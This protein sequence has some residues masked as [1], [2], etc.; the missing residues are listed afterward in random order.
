MTTQS[1]STTGGGPP[2]NSQECHR[3][4]ETVRTRKHMLC[5]EGAAPAQ[6]QRDLSCGGIAQLS[7]VFRSFHDVRYF[8]SGMWAKPESHPVCED[9]GATTSWIL[10]KDSWPPMTWVLKQ[11]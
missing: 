8:Y 11:K 9:P 5:A 2:A 7:W 4:S 1:N 3:P 10:G 6:L